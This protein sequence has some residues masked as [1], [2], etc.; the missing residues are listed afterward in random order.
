MKWEKGAKETLIGYGLAAGVLLIGSLYI[1]NKSEVREGERSLRQESGLVKVVKEESSTISNG[2]I[3]R[4]SIRKKPEIRKGLQKTAT[5][6]FDNYISAIFDI[7]SSDNPNAQRYEPGINDTSY[8]LG[9]ILTN[10]ALTLERRNPNLPRIS[11]YS[12]LDEKLESDERKLAEESLV[13]LYG[14]RARV[15]T[16]RGGW[17]IQEIKIDGNFEGDLVAQEFLRRIQ[18]KHNLRV[19]GELDDATYQAIQKERHLQDMLTNPKINEAYT[20]AL[21]REELEYFNDAELA[22][23]AYNAG[24]PAVINAAYQTMLNEFLGTSLKPDGVIGNKSREVIR[25]FQER[26]GLRVDGI[27]GPN[28][29]ARIREVYETLIGKSPLKGAMPQNRYTPNHVRKFNAA[30][31]TIEK[32]KKTRN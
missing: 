4:N 15:K 1:M 21:F 17:E 20:R 16:K 28:T 27:L 23:A 2:G 5:Y 19:K 12:G 6:D 14:K 3:E 9:Q 11:D 8:G 31:E 25:K 7:E 10:V 29:K 18:R 26:Y 22:V 32:H 24:R 13:R 30:L